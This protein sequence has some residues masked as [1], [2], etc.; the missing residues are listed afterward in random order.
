MRNKFLVIL[1]LLFS[2]FFLG[3]LLLPNPD[4]PS[5]P[6]GSLQSK[7]PAD[8]ETPLRRAYFTNL[9]R[10][11]VINHYKKE[12]NKGFSIYTPR[13][14]YPPEEAQTIIRDQTRSTFLEEIVH[15]FR[16]SI[17]INGFEPREAKD[18][19]NIEG[20]P[21]RQKII[22]RYV[23]SNEFIRIAI[24][25]ASLACLVILMREYGKYVKAD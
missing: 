4:F 8:T 22:V 24:G 20:L 17:Y 3:Y 23:P 16:E 1:F 12:F 14:N 10:E 21:W 15:P 18:A 25:L 7:E 9:T 6:P 11:E 5:P 2:L 13:L 19:I